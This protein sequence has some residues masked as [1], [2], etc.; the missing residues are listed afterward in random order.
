VLAKQSL[1]DPIDI[2][3]LIG[4]PKTALEELRLEIYRASTLSASA[5][6]IGRPDTVLD[7]KVLDYPTHA[8]SCGGRD[9]QLRGPPATSI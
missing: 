2:G 4:G 8:A 5:L 6:R 1:M 3:E 9:S 7:V